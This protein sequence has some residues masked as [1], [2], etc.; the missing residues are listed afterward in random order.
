MLWWW[1]MMMMMMMSLRARIEAKLTVEQQFG[2]K[3]L[4]SQR[5]CCCNDLTTAGS[6][7]DLEVALNKFIVRQRLRVTSR[8][9]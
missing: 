8:L 2:A 4:A 5:S 9:C 6:H 3:R 1:W 7:E